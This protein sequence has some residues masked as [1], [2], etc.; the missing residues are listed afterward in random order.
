MPVAKALLSCSVTR[1]ENRAH[2]RRKRQAAA[3]YGF[4]L[5]TKAESF[6]VGEVSPRESL[7]RIFQSNDRAEG[8]EVSPNAS[9]GNLNGQLFRASGRTNP[10]R[11]LRKRQP[12]YNE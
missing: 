6:L 7:S 2:E 12:K 4:S 11:Y 10:K 5:S 1:S 3:W 8:F 9:W